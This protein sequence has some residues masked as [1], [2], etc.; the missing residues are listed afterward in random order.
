VSAKERALD[1][2]YAEIP[3]IPACT[4]A[5]A[6]ACGPIAASRLEWER[7][8]ARHGRRPKMNPTTLQCP[9]LSPTGWCTVYTV[10][11]AICRLWGAVKE[12]A[13]PQGCEPTRWLTTEEAH[14]IFER[15]RVLD[16]RIDGT[17]DVF[18]PSV[19][20]GIG[21]EARAERLAIIEQVKGVAKHGA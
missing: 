20:E 18:P 16:P 4:G 11:P 8:S 7:V 21:I 12:M 15:I 1:E 19:W 9:M 6:V 3:A 5:C 13:C 14:S 17:M 10:R 2:I